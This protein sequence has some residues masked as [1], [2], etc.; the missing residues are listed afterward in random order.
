MLLAYNGECRKVN[1]CQLLGAGHSIIQGA[2]YYGGYTTLFHGQQ[3]L[4]IKRPLDVSSGVIGYKKS[5]RCI[6]CAPT[7]IHIVIHLVDFLEPITPTS[8]TSSGF[9]GANFPRRDTGVIHL[10]NVC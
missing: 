7:P 1:K 10:V 5:T 9:L 8:D 3:T 2:W 4:A 6:S